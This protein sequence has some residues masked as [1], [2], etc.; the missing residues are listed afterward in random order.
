[1]PSVNVPL[2]YPDVIEVCH[3]ILRQHFEPLINAD[4]AVPEVYVSAALTLRLVRLAKAIR[5]LCDAGLEEES[6]FQ[7]RSAI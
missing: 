6:Q 5:L 1:M 4:V 3:D 7:L 2:V